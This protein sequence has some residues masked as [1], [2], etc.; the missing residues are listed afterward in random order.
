VFLLV[1][2]RALNATA[3]RNNLG[4]A[5]SEL[6]EL[7]DTIYFV[8][9][10]SGKLFV[11][12]TNKVIFGIYKYNPTSLLHV[13]ALFTP[14]SGTFIVTIYTELAARPAG[15]GSTRDLRYVNYIF[16][17]SEKLQNI[18]LQFLN[19]LVKVP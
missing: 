11:H 18:N 13:S 8:H 17:Y 10:D 7:F 16:W 12:H 3:S 19:V 2:F 1:T 5:F 15:T 6:L 9:F 14:S 4:Q